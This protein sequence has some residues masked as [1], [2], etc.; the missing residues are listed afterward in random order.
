M[1][2]VGL[3]LLSCCVLI[4]I[5]VAKEK[6]PD[7]ADKD[8]SAELPRIAPKSPEQS[9]EAIK[10][11]AGFHAEIVAAEPLIRSP[12]GMDF[13]EFGRAFVIELP[14]YNQY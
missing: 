9:L 10:L 11:K 5:A 1:I 6:S 7:S 4:A 13:D 14:E 2:R 3:I 12:M 8:Y